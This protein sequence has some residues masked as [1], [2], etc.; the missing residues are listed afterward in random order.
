MGST[1]LSR[2]LCVLIYQSLV[3]W[4]SYSFEKNTLT[5]TKIELIAM[6]WKCSP[7]SLFWDFPHATMMETETSWELFF[8]SHSF[9]PHESIYAHYQGS[10][11]FTCL[12]LSHPLIHSNAVWQSTCLSIKLSVSQTVR[13]TLLFFI[14]YTYHGIVL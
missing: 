12:F 10:W 4:L 5:L 6:I 7:K 2:L 13:N 14:N 11:N 8:W 9:C 1:I 3:H